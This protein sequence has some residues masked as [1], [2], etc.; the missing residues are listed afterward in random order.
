MATSVQRTTIASSTKKEEP[1]LDI[2][3]LS[4]PESTITTAGNSSSIELD[5]NTVKGVSGNETHQLSFNLKN[6]FVLLFCSICIAYIYI[7]IPNTDSYY[8]FEL[9]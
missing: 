1:N 6:P 4:L 7:I 8:F 2:E 9:V 3:T 5:A